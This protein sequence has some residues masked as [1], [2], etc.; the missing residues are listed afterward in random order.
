MEKHLNG[1]VP[2]VINGTL[3]ASETAQTPGMIR[4][5]AIHKEST[6]ASKIWFGTVTCAPNYKGPPHHHGEAETAAYVVSGHVRVYYGE[7]FKDH[8]E[9][10]PGDYLFVPANTWHIEENPYDVPCEQFL[11][12]GPDNIVVNME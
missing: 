3:S 8:V 5:P 10:G 9:A 1:K 6:G 4:K 12:R 7:D 2:K 11:T